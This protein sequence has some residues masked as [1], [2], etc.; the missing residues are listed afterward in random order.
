MTATNSGPDRGDE[1]AAGSATCV[2]TPEASL[3]LAGF[4]A[5]DAPA[6]GV[7]TDLRARALAVCDRSDETLVL[8]SV[9]VIS[10]PPGMRDS[11]E[12]RCAE[13]YDLEPASVAFAATHTHCGPLLQEFRGRIYDVD[14]ELIEA[15]LAYRRRLEDALVDLV[16]DALAGRERARLSYGHA[17]CGFAMN[18]R[19]PTPNG[20][21]NGLHPDGLVDHDVPVL[22][23]K[24]VD[25]NDGNALE[26]IVFGYAC[27]ATTLRL[28][29][30][31]GDWPGYAMQTLEERYPGATALFL[32]GCA[33]DQKPHPSRRLEA[34]RQHGTAMANAVETALDAPRQPLNGPL[35]LAHEA[36]P[37]EFEGYD[38]RD[39]LEAMRSST[40]PYERRHADLLLERLDDERENLA[41]T[42]PYRMRAVG[43]GSGLTLFTLAGEV[44]VD[45][46]LALEDEI[47]GP[48]WI[49]AYTDGSF[50]YVPSRR[51]LAEGGYEGGD[52]TRFRRYPGR[53][54]PDVEDEVRSAARALAARVRG[55]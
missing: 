16:G 44:V 33:G 22:A 43:F 12:R 5:R 23:V 39:E 52:V 8:V 41:T 28:E 35:R 4:A 14:E 9:E 3:W 30:Y 10:I 51:V 55:P 25:E 32:T 17:R 29:R 42:Y 46:A 7:E 21:V 38:G 47:S 53:L 20:I 54:T 37:L 48:L 45:Y 2:I 18:R 6:A 26:A 50:T 27:H 11:L 1:W 34:A 40:D 15:S 36:I 24:S 49:A 13:R 31:C 19:Q